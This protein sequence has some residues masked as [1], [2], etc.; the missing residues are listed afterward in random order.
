[1]MYTLSLKDDKIFQKLIAKGK[2]YGGTF[3]SLYLLP[4]KSES[5]NYIGL[6][7]GKKVGKANKRNRI[8]RLIRESY[9]CM[10]KDVKKGYNMLFV[11]KSKASYE[12]ANYDLI[13][14][15]VH[16]ILKKAGLI[17]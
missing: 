14:K 13:Y 10:E 15:D 2:W 5:L 8:K 11:W 1:M 3:L 16:Y 12:D 17:I 7:I 4:N 6:G 9:K